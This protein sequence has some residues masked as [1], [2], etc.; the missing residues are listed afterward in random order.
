M[1]YR[2]ASSIS[3]A[4]QP[5][6]IGR[7]RDALRLRRYSLKTEKAYI[8]WV[9]RYVCFH[10]MR[11]P[12]QMGGGEVTTMSPAFAASTA[13]AARTISVF[14]RR[15]LRPLRECHAAAIRD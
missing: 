12:E 2:S 7:L 14:D 6:L 9:K 11:H 3:A 13:V 1:D 4:R 8:H 5:K 15:R 10:G